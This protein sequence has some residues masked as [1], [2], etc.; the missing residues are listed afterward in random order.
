M[1]WGRRM[2]EGLYVLLAMNYFVNASPNYFVNASLFSI[3]TVQ[4]RPVKSIS[5]VEY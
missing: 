5:V 4:R 2:L 3:K 1:S